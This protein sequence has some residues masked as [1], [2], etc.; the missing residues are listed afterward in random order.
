M[1]LTDRND[2]TVFIL[3]AGASYGDTLVNY[4]VDEVEITHGIPLTNQFF[5]LEY[6]EGEIEDIERD[7]P[8]LL[9]YIKTN[10]RLR[11]FASAH[12]RSLNLEDVF[13]SLG[14]GSKSLERPPQRR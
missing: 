1:S 14:L 6:L 12:W 11:K 4:E 9:K 5:Q 3:G 7:Y 8:E 13:T 10:W 2:R